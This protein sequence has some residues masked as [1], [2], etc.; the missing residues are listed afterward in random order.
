ML[1]D[2]AYSLHGSTRIAGQALPLKVLHADTRRAISCAHSAA[3]MFL[4]Q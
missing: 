2:E 3:V 1:W 4:P